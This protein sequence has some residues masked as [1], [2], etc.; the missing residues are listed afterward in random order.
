MP[1][2]VELSVAL[3]VARAFDALGLK[4][5]IGGSLA[6]SLHGVPRSS[7]DAD[8]L[9]EVPGARADEIAARL[10]S[11]FYVDAEMIREAVRRGASFNVVDHETGFK[12]DVFVLT[13]DTL[14]QSVV[15]MR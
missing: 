14:L 10:D 9:A 6:S 5:L 7:H 11:D 15:V 2:A 1:L 4:Y 3:K 13:R 12:V 8:L